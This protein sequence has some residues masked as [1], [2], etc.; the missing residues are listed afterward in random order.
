MN[1]TTTIEQ[2]LDMPADAQEK[3]RAMFVAMDRMDERIVKDQEETARMT[4]QI[5]KNLVDIKERLK[6]LGAK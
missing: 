1:K 3:I 6:K 4:P 5:E 2:I